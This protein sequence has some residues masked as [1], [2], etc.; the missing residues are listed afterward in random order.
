M[1]HDDI[2]WGGLARAGFA[3]IRWNSG[4]RS[5]VAEAPGSTYVST[6]S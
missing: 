3:I 6:R 5:F 4:R 1:D 2:E